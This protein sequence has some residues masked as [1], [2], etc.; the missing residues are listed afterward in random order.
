MAGAHQ[1]EIRPAT[2]GMV[3]L[4]P[5][6]GTGIVRFG[7]VFVSLASDFGGAT[8][9][10]AIGRPPNN[11]RLMQNLQVPAGRSI[12]FELVNTDQVASVV[13]QGGQPV[14]V[15]VEYQ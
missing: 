4:P 15:L 10:L 2:T 5:P 6:N 9:R 7:R 13:N 12:V 8:V 14:A 3:A 11:G 1:V